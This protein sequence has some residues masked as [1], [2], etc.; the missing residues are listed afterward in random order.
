MQ[1]YLLDGTGG[2]RRVDWEAIKAWTP[3]EGVLW[4]NLDYTAPDAV[5]WLDDDARIDP[6]VRDALLDTDPRPRATVHDDAL[7][8][9][10]RGI[11]MN[12]GS[13]P[14]DM[15]SVRSL[16]EPRRIITMRHRVSRS[17]KALSSDIERG[18]GAK[19]LGDLA[20]LLV[21][22]I[23]DHV[24]TRVDALGDADRRRARTRCSPRPAASYAP[25]SRISAAARSP[26]AGSSRRSAR[27]ST[28]LAADSPA[29][30]RRHA[31]RS[32]SPRQP[33]G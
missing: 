23:V 13:A 24:V 27:R 7:V 29:V 18:Q 12:Q 2:A 32:G 21:D 5:A 17:L 3:S 25:S 14:E 9:I 15:L 28:K 22:R 10:V 31:S 16:I 33:T 4:V 6:L 30:A 19:T 20:A 8:L 1:A 11:N 26:C